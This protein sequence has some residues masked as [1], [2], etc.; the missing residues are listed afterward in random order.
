[1]ID[2]FHNKKFNDFEKEVFY[3]VIFS[4]RD[5][6]KRFMDKTIDDKIIY[7]ILKAAHHTPSVGFSQPWNFILI[8]DKYTRIKIKDSF[9]KE[10][11]KSIEYLKDDKEKQKKYH[12][13]KLEGILES[14]LNICVT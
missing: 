9:L 13:L 8:K 5:I 4:R 1:M 7:N 12:K 14:D 3:N 6:R 10:R 11:L 2:N